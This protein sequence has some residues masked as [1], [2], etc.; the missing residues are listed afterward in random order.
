MRTR[1][2]WLALLLTAGMALTPTMGR[3]QEPAKEGPPPS[4]IDLGSILG[5]GVAP[6]ARGQLGG[7]PED[8]DVPQAIP[9]YPLPLGHDRMNTG[10]FFAA[11]EMLYQRQSNPLHH[12]LIAVRGLVDFDGSIH[13]D[14]DIGSV[15]PAGAKQAF[16]A[17]GIPLPGGFIGSAAPALFADQAGGPSTYVPGFQ[18]TLGYRFTEGFTCEISDWHLFN[19]RYI[20]GATLVPQGLQP[21]LFLENT[22]LFSP[23]YNFPTTYAGPAQKLALGNP[24]AAYGIWNGA[25]EMNIMFDQRYDEWNIGSRIPMMESDFCRC[26]GLA[27]ARHIWVWEDFRW[28]TVAFDFQGLGDASDAVRYDNIVSNEMYG[29]YIGCG[30]EAYMGHGFS[31][32]LDLTAAAMIDFVREY[33]K[34]ERLDFST[35]AKR[36]TRVFTIVPE[37]T[38][39]LSLTWYPIEGIELRL[40]YDVKNLFNTIAAQNPVT[41]NFNGVDPPY[42]H[43]AYRLVDGFHVGIAFIF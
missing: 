33:A 20:G 14:F 25:T 23:V 27:G 21:G 4:V 8:Y 40:G 35:E 16:L 29:G 2:G 5:P 7:E 30:T 32:K 11:G 39:D 15:V 43:E 6:V 28:T 12:Q 9:S 10:G 17:Q 31:L 36:S 42:S 13:Q 3:A 18:V 24:Q 19:A 22:F 38:A 34:F 41:F 37:L 1:T 26:Y